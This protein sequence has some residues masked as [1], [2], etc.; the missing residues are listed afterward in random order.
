MPQ[1]N[2]KP[3]CDLV[4]K[5]FSSRS[6]PDV[7]SDS[8]IIAVCGQNDY[9]N[10]AGPMA[11][12]W[13]FSEFYLFHHLFR[14]T[15]K[16]QY[17]L[18]CVNPTELSQKYN[19][20]CYGDPTDKRVVL[21]KTFAEEVNDVL[22]FQPDDL[23]E[24]FLSYVSNTCK[25][26]KGTQHPILI[27]IFGHG[28]PRTLS[29]TIG[30]TGDVHECPRLTS[31]KFKEAVYRHDSSSNL[32][33]LTTSCFGG[34]W[35][36]TRFLN[37]TATAMTG[38]ENYRELFS[39]PMSMS[40]AR[41]CGSRYARGVA[42]ALIRSE[43]YDLDLDS[44]QEAQ[45]SPTFSALVE[46]IRDILIKE[47]DVRERNTISFSAQDDV[48]DMRWRAR[49]GFPLNIYKEKWESLR[50][51]PQDASSDAALSTIRFSDTIRISIPEAEFRLKRL[52]F[53]YSKSNPGDD[54]AAKNHVVHY[55]CYRLLK[56]GEQLTKD[57]LEMLAGSLRYRMETI[58]TRATEYKDHLNIEFPDCCDCDISAY[59]SK[60]AKDQARD[61]KHSEI[62][63]MVTS[64]SLFDDPEAHEGMPYMKGFDYLAHMFTES[65]WSP[66]QIEGALDELVR[67]HGK[68]AILFL[69]AILSKVVLQEAI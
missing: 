47:I 60:L 69:A 27:L 8:T 15:A 22:V 52:A 36:Q 55:Y 13:V 65:G 46:M 53:D 17:W 39:W 35:T 50:V 61:H 23:L 26:P 31:A 1:E 25:A 7:N 30:G 9:K 3:K 44:E 33:L 29:I 12:G 42:K 18:T 21:D 28:Q 19:E 20:Y 6:P 11:D 32:A 59:D 51:I 64:R 16:R 14:G 63:K 34:G 37:I 49:T 67:V 10:N 48:R 4:E 68:Q 56:G 43:I 58:M 54:S 24:R 2:D 40:L 41:C 66:R 57:Q 45:Q 38:S 5:W 62:D